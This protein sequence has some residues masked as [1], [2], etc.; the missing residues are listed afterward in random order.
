MMVGTDNTMEL[1]RPSGL[2][3]LSYGTTI[4]MVDTMLPIGIDPHV[5]L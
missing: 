1:W 2:V 4:I 3:Y 5:Y